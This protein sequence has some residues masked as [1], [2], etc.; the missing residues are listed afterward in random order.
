M[1]E[2]DREMGQ[3]IEEL[4]L[5]ATGRRAIGSVDDVLFRIIC[6]SE[7]AS[8]AQYP[9]DGLGEED[10]R[11]LAHALWCIITSTEVESPL[12][13]KSHNSR[14]LWSV[15]TIR[16]RRNMDFGTDV[17]NQSTLRGAI[18]RNRYP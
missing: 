3:A 18:A 5:A 4:L 7:F 14:H 16:V 12:L 2:H 6:N 13:I 15:F 1:N 9:S 17:L 11:K 10:A 8:M